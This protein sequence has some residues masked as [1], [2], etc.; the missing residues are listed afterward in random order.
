MK[1]IKILRLIVILLLIAVIG[2]YAYE[3][4]VLKKDPTENLMRMVVIIAGLIITLLRLKTSRPRRSLDYY[5][6]QYQKELRNAF[7]DSVLDR[8]KLLCAVRL[9]NEDNFRKAAKYLVQLQPKC[10]IPDDYYA[11]GVFLALIYTD[12]HLCEQAVMMYHHLIGMNLASTTV[13]GNLGYVYSMMGDD[14]KTLSCYSRALE[15]DPKNAYAQHNIAKF[16]FDKHDFENAA[17]NAKKALELDSKMRPS[18]SLLA[19]IYAL[20]ENKEEAEK[21]FHLAITCGEKPDDLK[22]AIETFRKASD[23]EEQ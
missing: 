8:K 1:R 16:Y 9:Y 6:A 18:A 22:N 15:M 2:L 7:S 20:E 19:I 5:E 14:E 23:T 12:L 10:R 13:Y 3:V 17:E 11:V 4:A 21:Y